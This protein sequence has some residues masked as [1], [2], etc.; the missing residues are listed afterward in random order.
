MIPWIDDEYPAFPP[1]DE[2]LKD[3]DG[4]LCAGGNLDPMTLRRAYKSGIFPW[5]NEGQPILWWSPDP[6]MV[7]TPSS[8]RFSRRL[9][10]FLRSSG[11]TITANRD[12]EAVIRACASIRRDGQDGTWITEDMVLAYLAFHYVGHACSIEVWDE[13]NQLCG[14]LYGVALGRMFF[15]ESMFSNTSNA[16]KAALATLMQS[17][18]FDLVDCQMQT[19]HLSSQG[20][21]LMKRAEFIDQIKLLAERE[22]DDLPGAVEHTARELVNG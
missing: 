20:G 7:L 22:R 12:F 17:G 21:F 3:P 1:V 19:S 9:K 14:G 11:W 15:G 2:A 5:F 18:C 10:R 16:S 6:R 8:F 4:L 13:Q